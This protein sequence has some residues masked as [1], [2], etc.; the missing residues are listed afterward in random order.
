[1]I[2]L[3]VKT[4]AEFARQERE[5]INLELATCFRAAELALRMCRVRNGERAQT[6]A[7]AKASYETLAR[8]IEDPSRAK[9]LTFK[10]KHE[11]NQ[12]M[13]ALRGSLDQLRQ[14]REDP[15]RLVPT[16]AFSKTAE[17]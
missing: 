1:M 9:L 13:K 3:F 17:K 6:V 16:R 12:K 15:A 8:L 5:S 4:Q 14:C 10:A 7:E 11:L 2:D